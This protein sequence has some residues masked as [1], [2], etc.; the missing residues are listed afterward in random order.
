MQ[1]SAKPGAPDDRGTNKF[2]KKSH[3]KFDIHRNN[4]TKAWNLLTYDQ[5]QF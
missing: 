2:H 3:L 1:L 4:S 5:P